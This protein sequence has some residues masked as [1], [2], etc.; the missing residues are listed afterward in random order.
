M[1]AQSNRWT[2]N[3]QYVRDLA[4]ELRYS[5]VHDGFEESLDKI[6]GTLL[7]AYSRGQLD[8]IRTVDR[9]HEISFNDEPEV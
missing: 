2:W 6:I 5:A 7:Y 9:S 4:E 3:S 1:N 8:P